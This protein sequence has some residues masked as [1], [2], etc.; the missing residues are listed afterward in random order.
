MYSKYIRGSF[1]K[2]TGLLRDL[3]ELSQWVEPLE[4][5]ALLKHYTVTAWLLK[6]RK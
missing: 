3:R 1:Q 4:S 6:A 5:V 2:K